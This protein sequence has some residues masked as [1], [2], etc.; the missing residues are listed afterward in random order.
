VRD[1]HGIELRRVDGIGADGLMGYTK[2]F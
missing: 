2:D 1:E